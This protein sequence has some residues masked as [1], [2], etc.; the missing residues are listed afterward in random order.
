MLCPSVKF[1]HL[2]QKTQIPV[3]ARPSRGCSWELRASPRGW[4]QQHQCT[5]QFPTAL[6]RIPKLPLGSDPCGCWCWCPQSFASSYQLSSWPH[7]LIASL[8]IV[9]FGKSAVVSKWGFLLAKAS[10]GFPS[11][12][13]LL[14]C[15]EQGAELGQ[16]TALCPVSPRLIFQM[17]L[18]N[19]VRRNYKG[20]IAPP[21]CG[22]LQNLEPRSCISGLEVDLCSE[23]M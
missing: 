12:S 9:Y 15:W 18:I 10:T 11:V 19:K 2:S 5:E 22:T 8:L 23:Q 21:L 20:R 3:R 16:V 17:L 14:G 1:Q 7:V 13:V 4:R 6:H